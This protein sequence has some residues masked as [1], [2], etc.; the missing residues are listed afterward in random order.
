MLAIGQPVPDFDLAGIDSEGKE[1]R[2][3]LKGLLEAKPYLVLY[4]YPKDQ[5]PGCITEACAFRDAQSDLES[6]ATLVGISP[7]LPAS[8]LNFR[9]KQNLNFPLL[10]D[11]DK[12]MLR[13]YHAWGEKKVGGKI[14]EGVL[15]ITC[16][17]K[18]DGTLAKV[19]P[20]VKVKTHAEEVIE[21]IQDQMAQGD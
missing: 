11:P 10:S 2:F 18:A 13:A 4:F 17:I 15:R 12:D 20:K 7:D 9:T 5:T 14:K 6:L 16:L 3:T 1:G 8:H 21:E 19:W